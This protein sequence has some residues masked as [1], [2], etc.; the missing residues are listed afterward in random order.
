MHKWTCRV[1]KKTGVGEVDFLT[2]CPENKSAQNVKYDILAVAVVVVV[3][4][5]LFLLDDHYEW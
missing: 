3:L 4:K 5:M 1:V 2:L